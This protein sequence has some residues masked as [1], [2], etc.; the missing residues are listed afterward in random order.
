M[1]ENEFPWRN[2]EDRSVHQPALDKILNSYPILTEGGI[3]DHEDIVQELLS[4]LMPELSWAFRRLS[5]LLQL[6]TVVYPR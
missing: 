3:Y 4:R 6:A 2:L 1:L 5:L